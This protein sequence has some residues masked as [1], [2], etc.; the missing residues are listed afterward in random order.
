[1][2]TNYTKNYARHWQ[3]RSAEV[4]FWQ[5]KSFVCT[6]SVLHLPRNSLRILS[7]ILYTSKS[8][9]RGKV[10]IASQPPSHS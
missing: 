10:L 9:Q 7:D 6:I 1:M 5:M 8:E 3:T 4:K 2:N